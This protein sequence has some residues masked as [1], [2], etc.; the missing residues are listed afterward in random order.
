MD[1]NVF[2]NPWR[3]F[4]LQLAEFLP[5]LM[6]AFVILIIGWM[7]AKVTEIGIKRFLRLLKIDAIAEK[8][9]V[10]AF[11]KQGGLEHSAVDIL[12][13]LVY[14]VLMLIVI[15]I[16]LNG[17]GLQTASDLLNRIILYIPN[18]IVAVFVLIIGL[19]FARLLEGV[20]MTYLRNAGVENARMISEIARYALI[21]FVV[22]VALDQ[23]NIGKELVVSTFQI[24]FG[25]L[26]LA[27]A[28][29]FGLGGRDWAAGVISRL[30]VDKKEKKA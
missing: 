27:L 20:L 6:G 14:W 8:S 9:G 30:Q 10:D 3:A 23:L 28:L 17:M 29:A 5:R 7:I 13:I 21:V 19:F 16:A 2:L 18:V 12:G 1:T 24:A 22:S 11:L 26:C 15:L 4:A 25:A